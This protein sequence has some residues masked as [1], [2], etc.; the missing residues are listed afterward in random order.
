MPIRLVCFALCATLLVAPLACTEKPDS[1]LEPPP[2]ADG[3]SFAADIQPLFARNGCTDC[4]GTL[5]SS[6]YSVL[7]HEAVFGPGI[8]AA[9]RGMLEVVPA[10]PDSS[11]LVW[12]V[13]GAGPNGEPIFGQRMPLDRNPL[14][15]ADME[16]LRTWI[17]EGALDN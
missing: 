3:V 9:S 13:E 17:N 6:G 15:A 10:R 7:T 2:P 16:L 14:P 5:M 1:T 11:Y 4:H 8:E 12:K